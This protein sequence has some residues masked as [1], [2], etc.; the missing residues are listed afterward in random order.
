MMEFDPFPARHHFHRALDVPGF[1]LDLDRMRLPSGLQSLTLSSPVNNRF[2]NMDF[3]RHSGAFLRWKGTPDL[4]VRFELA[5]H[6]C[7]GRV[8]RYSLPTSKRFPS[9]TAL[10]FWCRSESRK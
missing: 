9:P 10:E 5:Y 6:V 7:P 2:S 4:L 3:P 1:D 8:C